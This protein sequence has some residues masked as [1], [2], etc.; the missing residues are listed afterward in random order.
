MGWESGQTAGTLGHWQNYGAGQS[1]VQAR[2]AG[3]DAEKLLGKLLTL[4]AMRGSW[5]AGGDFEHMSPI[6]G[7]RALSGA[8][9]NILTPTIHT[10]A[11]VPGYSP[12]TW[13]K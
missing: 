11:C 6:E 4:L 2:S 13:E 1:V 12:K 5:Q 9:S 10:V 3:L 7:R 8:A